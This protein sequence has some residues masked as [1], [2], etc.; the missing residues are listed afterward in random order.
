MKKGIILP[1]EFKAR[2]SKILG[3]ENK[4]FLD[5]CMRPLRKSIRINTLKIEKEKCL[6]LLKKRGWNLNP[7]PWYENGFWVDCERIEE[8]LGNTLEY[9]MGYYYIQE[10][11]S[12]IPP[13]VLKPRERDFV[14]DMAASPGSKTGQIA[15]MMNN[16]GCVIA[17]DV[18]IDRLKMLKY[19]LE[20]LGV[21]NT[22]VSKIDGRRFGKLNLKFD[23]ILVDAPCSSEGTVRKNWKALSRWSPELIKYMSRIQKQMLD[24][25]VHC[26]ESGGVLVYS[27]CTLA[28]EENEGVIDY[29]L[30]KYL[31]MDVEPI[32]LKGLKYREGLKEWNGTVFDSRVRKCARIWPQDNDTEG[33]F[34][35]KLVKL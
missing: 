7:I 16:K 33:F 32:K 11:S 9:F 26:L 25:A 18:R 24:S 21:M 19:N 20:K 30:K 23:K 15:E 29:I 4:R 8:Q 14:L 6:E 13:A 12:M 3:T 28:P 5:Y 1:K 2:Y 31:D 35:A 22:V 10:A 34:V 27:T 17:N